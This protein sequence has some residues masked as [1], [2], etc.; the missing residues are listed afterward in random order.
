MEQ[1]LRVGVK[2]IKSSVRIGPYLSPIVKSEPPPNV[3]S[4]LA[5]IGFVLPG[6]A[7]VIAIHKNTGVY[8]FA[9]KYNILQGICKVFNQAISHIDIVIRQIHCKI[10]Q[11]VTFPLLLVYIALFTPLKVDS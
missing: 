9:L 4:T 11:N 3:L 2:E 8:V 10:S 6:L 5:K 7:N 1:I